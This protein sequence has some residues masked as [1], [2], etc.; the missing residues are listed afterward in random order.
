VANEQSGGGNTK[1]ILAGVLLLAGAAGLWAMLQPSAPEPTPEPPKKEEVE[2]VNPMAQ[3]LIIEDEPTKD[4]AVAEPEPEPEPEP[5][6]KR[7]KKGPRR[8]KPSKWDCSGDMARAKLQ[9]VIRNN[10]GQVRTCYERRLKRNNMLQGALNLKIR[11]GDGGKVDDTK[12]SGSLKDKEVFQ[13]VSKIAKSW[14]FPVPDGGNCAVISIPFQF[15]P[16]N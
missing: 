7:R 9:S 10:R 6:K 1:F 16:K 13:C 12:V 3:Q 5:K 11:V 4:A 2:R 14:T 15:S 8:P